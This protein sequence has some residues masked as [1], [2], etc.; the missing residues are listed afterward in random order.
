MIYL[1]IFFDIPLHEHCR[2][3]IKFKYAGLVTFDLVHKDEALVCSPAVA[4]Y[5]VVT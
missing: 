2:T 3:I 5:I 4:S 1:N